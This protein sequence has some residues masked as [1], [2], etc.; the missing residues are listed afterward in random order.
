MLKKISLLSALLC[1]ISPQ[2]LASNCCCL[3]SNYF[4]LG[5]GAGMK[6]TT[7]RNSAAIGPIVIPDAIDPGVPLEI[8]AHLNSNNGSYGGSGS[9]FLGYT[10]NCNRLHFGIE[11]NAEFNSITVDRR[12]TINAV[13]VI[14]NLSAITTQFKVGTSY[15]LSILPGFNLAPNAHL[16]LRGGVAQGQIDA[17]AITPLSQSHEKYNKSGAQVGI[18]FEYDISHNLN[19]RTE[20]TCVVYPSVKQELPAAINIPDAVMLDIPISIDYRIV[21]NTFN[22]SLIYKF[23]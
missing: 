2:I 19:L 6:A 14:P 3:P 4:Y 5:I 8:S 20:Y 1:V 22:L 18:G 11:A 9:G 23:C 13:P 7:D 17:L 12:L 15:G 10:Y 21:T 16:F